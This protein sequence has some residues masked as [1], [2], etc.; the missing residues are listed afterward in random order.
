MKVDGVPETVPSGAGLL[1]G[2]EQTGEEIAELLAIILSKPEEYAGMRKAAQ[3][4]SAYQSW[5]RA[6]DRFLALLGDGPVTAGGAL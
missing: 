3:D 2:L 1:V 4:A 5:N 6:A